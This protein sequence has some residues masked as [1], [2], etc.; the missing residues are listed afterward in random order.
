MEY[1][2]INHKTAIQISDK[3][4]I[5]ILKKRVK[6]GYQIVKVKLCCEIHKHKFWDCDFSFKHYIILGNFRFNRFVSSK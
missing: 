2:K 6:L 1:D 5:F 4:K 3:S